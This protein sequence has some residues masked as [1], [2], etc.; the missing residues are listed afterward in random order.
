MYSYYSFSRIRFLICCIRLIIRN[1]SVSAHCSLGPIETFFNILYTN[2]FL[3]NIIGIGYRV[4][5][6]QISHLWSLLVGFLEVWLQ[7]A[8]F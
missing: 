3:N 2:I 5:F 8:F 4:G 1:T 6:S 7:I